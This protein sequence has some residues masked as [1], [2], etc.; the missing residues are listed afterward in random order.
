M[1]LLQMNRRMDNK[2]RR[3][4]TGV[5]PHP[6]GEGIPPPTP[7]LT[8]RV[9]LVDTLDAFLP[10]PQGRGEGERTVVHPEV[11]LISGPAKA[12]LTFTLKGVILSKLI[13]I[14]LRPRLSVVPQPEGGSDVGLRAIEPI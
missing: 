2:A 9:R 3:S 10:L 6:R 4:Q 7:R 12:Q 5:P 1:P 14:P 11:S 8:R 13:P